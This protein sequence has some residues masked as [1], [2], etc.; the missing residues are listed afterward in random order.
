MTA[1]RAFF[2][3]PCFEQDLQWVQLIYAHHVV[4]GAGTFE[5]E[6]PSLEEMTARW[7]RAVSRGWPYL[8]A[9][10]VDDPTRILGYAYAQQ[11]R[12]RAAYA[13]TLEDSIYVAPMAMGA[14]VGRA[15]L[16]SLL[17][18]AAAGGA[19]QIIAVIG[20]SANQASIRTHAKL[21]FE[22][23]GVLRNVGYKFGRWL[24]VVLMQR[25]LT[26]PAA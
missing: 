1:K 6:P 25:N 17:Q 24:D 20:D 4:T 14:G 2:I 9:S 21:G 18:E 3:R 5:T 16:A 22:Q 8:V 23:A 12:D 7:S 13:H 15:L 11:F 19:R 26:A 10:S